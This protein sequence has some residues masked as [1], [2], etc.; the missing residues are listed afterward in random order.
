MSAGASEAASIRTEYDDGDVD[1]AEHAELV[2]LLEQALL[3]LRMHNIQHGGGRT[4]VA[5]DQRRRGDESRQSQ[6]QRAGK[7]WHTFKKVTA[8]FRS[9]CAHI[10]AC[11]HQY[12]V[13]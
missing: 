2:R 11:V 8:R 13:S 1:G 7:A 12:E 3:S 9:F 10:N 4:G 6:K 5:T